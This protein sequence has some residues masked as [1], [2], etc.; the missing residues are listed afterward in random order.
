MYYLYH[1]SRGGGCGI[2]FTSMP[3]SY[4][5][6]VLSTGLRHILLAAGRLA[7][8]LG[9]LVVAL[10]LGGRLSLW[11]S[12]SGVPRRRFFLFLKLTELS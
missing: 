3:A 1:S 10:A 2:L 5:L 6:L 9:R 7:L 12:A 11:R 8:G 4:F